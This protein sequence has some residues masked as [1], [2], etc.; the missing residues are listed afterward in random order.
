MK[1]QDLTIQ[2]ITSIDI[3]TCIAALLKGVNVAL[4]YALYNQ[5]LL[6]SQYPWSLL[7]RYIHHM[8]RGKSAHFI[9]NES[10]KS[11]LE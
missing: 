9:S 3:S 11:E 10:T 4:G 1:L 6:Q 7:L 8:F 5:T 2:Q